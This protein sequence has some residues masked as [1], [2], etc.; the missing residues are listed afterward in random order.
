MI[1]IFTEEEMKHINTTENAW[2][3]KSDCPDSM[4][5]RIEKKLYYIYHRKTILERR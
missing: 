1:V 3:I 4:R 2:T 5:K